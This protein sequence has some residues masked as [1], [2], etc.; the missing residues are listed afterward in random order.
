MLF[1]TFK[2]HYLLTFRFSC[3]SLRI[4]KLSILRSHRKSSARQKNQGWALLNI[5]Y[6]FL[7]LALIASYQPNT[8]KHKRPISVCLASITR[9]RFAR[10]LHLEMLRSHRKTS[11]LL[12]SPHLLPTIYHEAPVGFRE[13]KKTEA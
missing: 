4:L 1:N 2:K 3:V 10:T 9:F 7:C 6:Q 13:I 8:Y 11:H 12:S 5:S